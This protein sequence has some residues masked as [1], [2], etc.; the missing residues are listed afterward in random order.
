[1][2]THDELMNGA[3]ELAQK[4][5]A[6]PPISV[7]FAKRMVWRSRFD[8]LARQADMESWGT[9]VCAMTDDFRASVDAFK[10]KQPPP[11]YRGQ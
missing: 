6:Q 11:K 2:V 3:D 1:M 5:M 7:L 8:D 4:I 9:R 10:N